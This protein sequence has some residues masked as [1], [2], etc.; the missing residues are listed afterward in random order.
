MNC[1]TRRSL[2]LLPYTD[3]G[4]VNVTTPSMVG[5]S[6]YAGNSGDQFSGVYGPAS[7]AA[8]DSTTNPFPWPNGGLIMSGITYDRSSVR[9][10]HITDGPSQTILAGEKYLHPDAYFNGADGADND[11]WDLGYDWDVNRFGCTAP[12]QDT[13]G[14]A[15][16]LAYGS[17]HPAG[18]GVVFCDGSVH[19]LNYEIDATLFSNLTNRADGVA[20]DPTKY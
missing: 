12:V 5:K 9:M 3:R 18:F 7:L 13:A 1:P 10:S 8:G 17:A 11:A 4:Y 6:D 15:N 20:I 16:L 19:V 2:Q 14:Y